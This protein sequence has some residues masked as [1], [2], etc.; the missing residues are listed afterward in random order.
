MLG[1]DWAEAMHD[2]SDILGNPVPICRSYPRRAK[3]GDADCYSLLKVLSKRL[4]A[5]FV[6]G[7]RKLTIE[8][9]ATRCKIGARGVMRLAKGFDDQP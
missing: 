1:G 6:G 4:D 8:V 2:Q 5:I 7:K 3:V 9:L